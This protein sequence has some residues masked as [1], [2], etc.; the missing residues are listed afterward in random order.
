M[1]VRF[2]GIYRLHFVSAKIKR[3]FSVCSIIIIGLTGCDQ[4]P[5]NLSKQEDRLGSPILRIGP[6]K[7][8]YG[9]YR[10][11]T[12]PNNRILVTAE[13]DKV[14]RFWSPADGRFLGSFRAPHHSEEP[15]A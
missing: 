14:L 7:Q 9:L 15:D 8:F 10:L 1:V 11:D 13:S 3:F 6:N 12:D 5:E 2:N 4:G